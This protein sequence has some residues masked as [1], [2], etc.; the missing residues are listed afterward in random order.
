MSEFFVGYTKDELVDLCRAKGVTGHSKKKVHELIELLMKAGIQPEKKGTAKEPKPKA[1]EAAEAEPKEDDTTSVT[2]STSNTSHEYFFRASWPDVLPHLEDASVQL[3][4]AD[5]A[6]DSHWVRECIR[7]LEPDGTLAIRGLSTVPTGIPSAYRTSWVTVGNHTILIVAQ[8]A[9]TTTAKTL[10][11]F[12][13]GLV[14]ATRP[15]AMVL[16]PFANGLLTR[17]LGQHRRSFVA[18]S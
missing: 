14:A 4:I 6:T 11:S 8:D 12:Y 3:V 7:V 2:S 9:Y 13:E 17:T 1:A 18:M 15:D 10:E 5:P 16:L